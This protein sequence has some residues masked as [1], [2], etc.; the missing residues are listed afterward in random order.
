MLKLFSQEKPALSKLLH[1][2]L[3]EWQS[4][5][6]ILDEFEV[7]VCYQ[8]LISLSILSTLCKEGKWDGSCFNY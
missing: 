8:S 4:N 7:R 6:Q 1:T 3:M 5:R 2:L